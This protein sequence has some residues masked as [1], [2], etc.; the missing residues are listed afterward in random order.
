[1]KI[2]VYPE[3]LLARDG[4][5]SLSLLRGL[6][7]CSYRAGPSAISGEAALAERDDG[8]CRKACDDG[9]PETVIRAEIVDHP[10]GDE[11]A[12]RHA[13]TDAGHHPGHAFRQHRFRHAALDQAE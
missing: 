11:G 3:R 9:D 12:E 10:A 8:D 7:H 6:L 4:L 1:M 13:D 5:D 2:R